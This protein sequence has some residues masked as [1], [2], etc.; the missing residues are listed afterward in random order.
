MNNIV[1][2]T[3][4]SFC[5]FI[6]EI[7]LW[8]IVNRLLMCQEF[9]LRYLAALPRPA[10]TV[11]SNHTRISHPWM[12]GVHDSRDSRVTCSGSREGWAYSLEE[13]QDVLISG[14]LR[15]GTL[16]ECSILQINFQ[17]NISKQFSCS[18]KL[19]KDHFQNCLIM[20]SL[21]RKRYL[22]EGAAVV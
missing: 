14:I 15:I 22:F 2:S 20:A 19:C 4:I 9:S 6:C 3:W 13:L 17:Q 7:A 21:D 12:L 16:T 5:I 10:S 1:N 18:K 11:L 8:A